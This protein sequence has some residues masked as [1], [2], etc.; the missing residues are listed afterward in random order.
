M[1]GSKS[2][3]QRVGSCA[4]SALAGDSRKRNA[5]AAI[6]LKVLPTWLMAQGCTVETSGFGG[7]QVIDGNAAGSKPATSRVFGTAVGADYPAS[8]HELAGFALAGGGTNLNHGAIGR[9]VL[10]K[11][12]D[13]A[14]MG[15]GRER[16]RGPARPHFVSHYFPQRS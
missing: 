11:W 9:V 13:S 14:Q 1:A 4:P 3:S 8:A 2:I 7:L 5:C 16:L 12:A 15:A 10:P 6:S